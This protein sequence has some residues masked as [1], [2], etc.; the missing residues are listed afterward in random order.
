[1]AASCVAGSGGRAVF[2]LNYRGRL[3]GPYLPAQFP[4][5]LVQMGNRPIKAETL[6]NAHEPRKNHTDKKTYK[7]QHVSRQGD[8]DDVQIAQLDG[9]GIGKGKRDYKQDENHH[10]YGIDDFHNHASRRYF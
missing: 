3:I 4:D 8:I 2:I 5:R 9:K 7:Y 10:N 1:M 6:D